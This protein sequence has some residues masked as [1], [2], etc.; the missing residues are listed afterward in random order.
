MSSN[1]SFTSGPKLIALASVVIGAGVML[2]LW[3]IPDPEQSWRA[4]VRLTAR[5]SALL[6]LLAFGA[7]AATA[8]WPGRFTQW[9]RRNRRYLGLSFA[10]SHTIHAFTFVSLA[11]LTATL[12][13]QVLS[14]GMLAVG[15]LGYLFVYALAATSSDV[16]QAILGMRW[17]RLLH[18]V[19]THWLWL[20]FLISF[21]KHA[22]EH[23]EDWIGVLLVLA[24]MALRIAARLKSRPTSA[25][26]AAA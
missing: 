18:I 3:W 9:T 16:A 10:A 20:Q 15:G 7:A 11:G 24:V 2:T 8:L 4:A 5:S 14:T 26:V 6:F 22:P 13:S 25:P 19:G 21:V 1:A 12:G 23:P 17:W